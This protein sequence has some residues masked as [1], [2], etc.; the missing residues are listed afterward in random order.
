MF[1]DTQDTPNDTWVDL[2]TDGID[3]MTLRALRAR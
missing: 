1:Y 3:F 2:V